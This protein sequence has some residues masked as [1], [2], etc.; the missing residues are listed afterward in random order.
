MFV[1]GADVFPRRAGMKSAS[2][3]VEVFFEVE[4][5]GDSALNLLDMK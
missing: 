2:C 3:R 4:V 5:E 1:R